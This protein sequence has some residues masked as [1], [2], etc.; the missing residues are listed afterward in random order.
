MA[1]WPP[2]ALLL[3]NIP[4]DFKI[5]PSD[6]LTYRAGYQYPT[7][8]QTIHPNQPPPDSPH[9]VPGPSGPSPAGPSPAGPSLTGPS[10]VGPSAAGP[11]AAG[12]PSGDPTSSAP[13]HSEPPPPKEAP[14]HGHRYS[15]AQRVQALTLVTEGFSGRD[16]WKKTG[17][18][19]SAVTNIKKRAYDR[20]YRPE[21]DSRILDHYVKDGARSGRPRKNKVA[22]GQQSREGG[23]TDKA[24]KGVSNGSIPSEVDVSSSGPSGET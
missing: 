14:D 20:G 6:E 4:P 9:S 23:T 8:L 12:P 10:P 24:N 11:S 7:Y 21:Q 17:V 18:K 2:K 13:A 1:A 3:V 5:L 16:I 15:F 19:P 22:A